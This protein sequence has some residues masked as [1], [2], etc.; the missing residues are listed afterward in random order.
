MRIKR[1]H[2]IRACHTVREAD[3]FRVV[4]RIVELL[5]QLETLQVGSLEKL[6]RGWSRHR[7][8]ILLV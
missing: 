7:L 8:L 6:A 3:H 1:L 5:R 4:L 2:L